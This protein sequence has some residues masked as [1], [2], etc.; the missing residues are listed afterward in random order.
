MQDPSL[1]VPRARGCTLQV[2]GHD[3]SADAAARAVVAGL[4]K[5]APKQGE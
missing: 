4:P 2:E 5:R 1:A 3:I